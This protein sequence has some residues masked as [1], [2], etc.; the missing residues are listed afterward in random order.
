MYRYLLIGLIAFTL[1]SCIR[2][3]DDEIRGDYEPV[4]MSRANFENE[5]GIT[6]SQP[7]ENPGKIYVYGKF[8]FVNEK[9]KGFHIYDNR[10][11]SSPQKVKFLKA[12][13]A[14]DIAIK[15]QYFYVNQATDLLTFYYDEN[16][17]AYTLTKRVRNVFPQKRSPQGRHP[18][19]TED[20]V[21]VDWIE[22]TDID[23]E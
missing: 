15:G 9:N 16:Q 2:I 20:E 18:N 12:F 10:Y 23:D 4:I 1:K 5:V 8:L 19:V 22:K 7:L 14:T 17:N 11:P 21:V 6:S 13:G 3:G